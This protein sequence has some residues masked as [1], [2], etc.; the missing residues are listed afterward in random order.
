[1][2]VTKRRC[3]LCDGHGI[4]EDN[5]TEEPTLFDVSPAEVAV[6]AEGQAH[7]AAGDTERAAALAVAPRTGTLRAL[8]LGAFADCAT[9]GESGLTDHELA[10]HLGKYLYSIAPRRTELVH[11]GWLEDSTERRIT[12]NGAQAVVWRLSPTGRERL[13]IDELLAG[14]MVP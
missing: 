2:P 3:P 9:A 6:P 5:V 14:A 7:R 10:H 13:A 1:M 12:P 11:G 4:I 8:V